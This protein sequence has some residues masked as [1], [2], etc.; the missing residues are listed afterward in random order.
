MKQSALPASTG[1][2]AMGRIRRALAK[3]PENRPETPGTNDDGWP[4]GAEPMT[5]VEKPNYP[6]LIELGRSARV[7]ADATSD[8]GKRPAVLPGEGEGSAAREH[9]TDG[10]RCWCG[11]AVESYKGIDA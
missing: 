4:M 1:G 11:P 8:E 5:W 6:E 9:V 2:I 7:E 10:S 3:T